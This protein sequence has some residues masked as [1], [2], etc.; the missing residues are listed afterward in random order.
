[1]ISIEFLQKKYTSKKAHLIF[2]REQVVELLKRKFKAEEFDYHD[3]LDLPNDD[4]FNYKNIYTAF[5]IKDYKILAKLFNETERENHSEEVIDN[6][7][8]PLNFNKIKKNKEQIYNHILLDEQEGRRLDIILE[9]DGHIITE[10]QVRAESEFL[11]KY[12]NSLTVGAKLSKGSTDTK[13]DLKDEDFIF[14]LQNLY[15]FGF[16]K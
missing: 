16:I 13:E 5:A 1:M 4:H 11:N 12:L 7:E 2:S 10:F 8:N 6:R 14:Y 9:S 3:L 15:E